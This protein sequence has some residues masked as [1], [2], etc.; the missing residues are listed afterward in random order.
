ML[1]ATCKHFILQENFIA[2]IFL[3]ECR[4]F[5]ACE[6]F[7]VSTLKQAKSLQIPCKK[8]RKKASLAQLIKNSASQV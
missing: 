6:F 3:L 7:Q 2:L 5:Q 1:T 4:F 8:K